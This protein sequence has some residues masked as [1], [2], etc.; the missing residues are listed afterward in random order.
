MRKNGESAAFSPNCIPPHHAGRAD[1]R[2][3]LLHRQ[4]HEG[5]RAALPALLQRYQ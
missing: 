4:R 3:Q 1:G 5:L 2:L